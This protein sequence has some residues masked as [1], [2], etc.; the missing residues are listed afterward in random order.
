ML[1]NHVNVHSARVSH[2]PCTKTMLFS[3]VQTVQTL[4]FVCRSSGQTWET[5]Q[6]V[7][8]KKTATS[9]ESVYSAFRPIATVISRRV[10]T[11]GV[12]L[13]LAIVLF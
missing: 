10:Q 7:S 13:C 12:D 1:R 9:I 3:K 5:V 2:L 8:M 6:N 11:V 4:T